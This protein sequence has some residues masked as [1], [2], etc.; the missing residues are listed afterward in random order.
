MPTMTNWNH[1]IR[2][3]VADENFKAP[4]DIAEVLA[5]VV[6]ASCAATRSPWSARCTPQ[7]SAWSAVGSSFR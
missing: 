3:Q 2:F 7:P 4:T 6:G 5:A 1:E